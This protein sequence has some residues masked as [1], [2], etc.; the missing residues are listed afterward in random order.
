MPIQAAGK[1]RHP[2]ASAL[3]VFNNESVVKLIIEN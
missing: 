1:D 2:A 3:Q